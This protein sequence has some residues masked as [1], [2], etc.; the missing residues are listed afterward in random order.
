MPERLDLSIAIK[1]ARWR[2]GDESEEVSEEEF[3]SKRLPVLRRD[4]FR[5]RYCGANTVPTLDAWHGSLEASGYFEIHHLDDDH[6]NNDLSNLV[7]ACPFCHSVM[8]LG[9]AGARGC[10]VLVWNPGI[11][12]ASLNLIMQAVL[13][14][15][16][17]AAHESEDE[18]ATRVGAICEALYFGLRQLSGELE[19][20]YGQGASDPFVMGRALGELNQEDYAHRD[21]ALYGVRFVP[22]YDYYAKRHLPYWGEHVYKGIPASTW[23]ELCDAVTTDA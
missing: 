21:R 11:D 8:H 18:T 7:T 1:R 10:G 5:C 20:R 4:E 3:R 6:E 22:S 2:A 13:V 15:M 9:N 19:E 16:W 14:G 23:E 17:R 12:Q